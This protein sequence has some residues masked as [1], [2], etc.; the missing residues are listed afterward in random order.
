MNIDE[1]TAN[2]LHQNAIDFAG[3][4]KAC[5]DAGEHTWPILHLC[6]ISIELSLKGFLRATTNMNIDE[7][8]KVVWH[9]LNKG[10]S[11]ANENGL[12]KFIQLDH[13]QEL[14]LSNLS[15][16]YSKRLFEYPEQ[17]FMIH[18]SPPKK[19]VELAIL[20]NTNLEDLCWEQRNRHYG[21][22]SAYKRDKIETSG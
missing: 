5:L 11:V 14:E 16:Y 9:D 2:M 13:D 8:R 6:G 22:P 15:L 20:F 18:P 17:P 7:I 19:F 4:A 3:A 10:L 21:K 1:L 12:K